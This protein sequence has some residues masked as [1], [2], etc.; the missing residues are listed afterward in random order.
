[1]YAYCGNNPVN[2]TDTTGYAPKINDADLI[3]Q[4]GG[5]LLGL[6]LLPPPN[7]SEN[8]MTSTTQ[9]IS[10]WY[11]QTKEDIKQLSQSLVD[12]AKKRWDD[13]QPCIHHVVPQGCTCEAATLARNVIGKNN[14]QSPENLVVIDYGTHRSIHS[15]GH[16][17]CNLVNNALQTYGKEFGMALTKVYIA[18]ESAINGGYFYG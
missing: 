9:V 16:M 1:M 3:A 18:L 15:N 4:V 14:V 5:T 7:T 2:Y 17:Y 10:D 8:W 13:F 12:A 6:S 11:A